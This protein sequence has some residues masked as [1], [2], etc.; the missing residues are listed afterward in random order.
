MAID[1][2]YIG[3][4]DRWPELAVTGKQSVWARGQEEER[5]DVEGLLL[6]ATGLFERAAAA[7][8]LTSTQA[9]AVKREWGRCDTQSMSVGTA[10]GSPGWTSHLT[11]ESPAE[12][13]HVQIGVLNAETSALTGVTGVIAA[14]NGVASF[15]NPA[16]GS[17]L[18]V[19]W[20]GASSATAPARVS[21][22]E[23]S[24]LLSDWIAVPSLARVDGGVNPVAMARS[25]VPSANATFSTSSNIYTGLWSNNRI[26]RSRANGDFVTTT[27]GWPNAE[28]TTSWLQIMRF[29]GASKRVTVMGCGDSTF[30]GFGTTSNGPNSWGLVAERRGAFS[31]VNA[32]ISGQSTT[33]YLARCLNQVNILRPS[34]A[35]WL[36]YSS[37]DGTPTQALADAAWA[38]A[39]QFVVYCESIGVAPMIAT[40]IPY[41]GQYTLAQDNIRKALNDKARASGIALFDFDAAITD[42]GA[43]ASIAAGLGSDSRHLNDAGT[44]V[45]ETRFAA[46]LA[47]AF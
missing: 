46:D 23:P 15:F 44:L 34:V 37:N 19:T 29:R 32:G 30:A 26:W 12:F 7:G 8:G 9:A 14:S 28:G 21:A 1:I 43:P 17:W 11:M 47:A 36:L 35:V 24:I 27:T 18:P 13:T 5:S 31:W 45:A 33:T 2:K 41:T 25:F 4:Q 16:G 22:N 42:G 10:N 38:R 3:T 6:L 40:G 20:A 39:I